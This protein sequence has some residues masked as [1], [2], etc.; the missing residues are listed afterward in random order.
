MEMY[1]EPAPNYDELLV[2]R[3]E[4]NSI[5][6]GIVGS[7]LY[8]LVGDELNKQYA[9]IKLEKQDSATL[10]SLME[11]KRL[12][13][14]AL[15]EIK[16]ENDSEEFKTVLKDLLENEKKHQE[17]LLLIKK[18][19]EEKQR[20]IEIEKEKKRREE[21]IRRQKALEE[22]RKKEIEERTRRLLDEKKTSVITSSKDS[23]KV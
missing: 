16:E 17:E 15:Q 7:E 1:K 12:K 23:N 21:I 19:E 9:T 13:I 8:S 22:E 4:M 10:K 20:L 2:K 14:A 5:L 11:E 18:K 3:E 6:S